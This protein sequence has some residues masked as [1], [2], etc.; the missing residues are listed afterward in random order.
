MK[1]MKKVA[2]LHSMCSV[3]KASLTNMIPI[4]STMGIEACAIPTVLLST[5]TGGYGIPATYRVEAEYIRSCA[6]HYKQNKILFDIIFVGYLGSIDMVS[7]VQYFLDC[8]PD[9]SVVLDPILGDHGSYYRNLGPEYVNAFKQLISYADV[10]L[11][12]LTEACLLTDTAYRTDLKKETMEDVCKKLQCMGA[13]QVIVTSVPATCTQVGLALLNSESMQFFSFSKE[14]DEFH[15]SGD[16]FDA[17]FLGSL[18]KGS[19]TETCIK[20]AH[21]FVCACIRE[22]VKYDYP[23]RE[24]LLVEK[25]LSLLV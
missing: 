9:A 12:N 11:P 2:L 4:L 25:T 1:P 13:K 20:N 24:G 19:P 23:K 18:L 7:S 21:D 5:H 3:G 22:S 15:G 10:L 16:V 17:V 14:Q 6:E 8:F